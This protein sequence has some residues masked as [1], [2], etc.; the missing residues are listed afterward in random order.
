M[1][2][3]EKEEGPYEFS[4]LLIPILVVVGNQIEKI[5]RDFLWGRVGD[6]F[7]LYLVS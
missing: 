7:K 3:E 1:R 2:E 4:L 6:N 5:H